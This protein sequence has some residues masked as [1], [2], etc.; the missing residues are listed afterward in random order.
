MTTIAPWAQE[1]RVAQSS[2]ITSLETLRICG[3]CLQPFIPSVAEK[4]LDALGIPT[5]ERTWGFAALTQRDNSRDL[6]AK[7]KVG[8]I[9]HGVKL[10]DDLRARD[11]PLTSGR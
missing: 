9:T 2:V 1:T 7:G 5:F 11:R 10:F 3:I 8:M 6:F 4:L